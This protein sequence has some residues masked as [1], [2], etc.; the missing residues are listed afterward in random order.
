MAL[1]LN[2][3]EATLCAM[4]EHITLED[5]QAT[6]KLFRALDAMVEAVW[7][8]EVEKVVDGVTHFADGPLGQ[9]LDFLREQ[10]GIDEIFDFAS[11]GA[12]R[13]NE[14]NHLAYQEVSKQHQAILKRQRA[15]PAAAVATAAPKSAIA[16]KGKAP[17]N[18]T[19]PPALRARKT[20]A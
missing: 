19:S 16:K 6:F 14:L 13:A 4:R 8:N 17:P 10:M 12:R 3:Q 5:V 1:S 20:S 15:A 11:N 18:R 9:G 7:E 2:T